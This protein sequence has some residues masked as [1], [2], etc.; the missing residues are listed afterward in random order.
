MNFKRSIFLKNI[1]ILSTGTILSQIINIG[2][3]PVLS[4]LYSVEDFGRL[5]LFLAFG[6]I[7]FSFSTL[8]LDLAIVKT[9]KEEEKM[10]LLRMAFLAVLPISTIA[11]V[12]LYFMSFWYSELAS[13]PIYLLFLFFIVNGG[14]Q[15]L[16]YYFN[17]RKRYLNISLARVL[18][19][20]TNLSFA[21]IL[22]YSHTYW[23][24]IYAITLANIFSFGLLLFY[25]RRKVFKSFTID[26]TFYQQVLLR[27][28]NFVKYSMPASFLDIL[29]YQIIIIILS[30]SFSEEVTG[31]FF[32]AMR[33]VLLPTTI[34][35]AAIGQVFYK[36]ISDKYLQNNLTK[37]EFLK[38]WK[39]LF[40]IG[41]L[42]LIFFLFYGQT[43]FVWALGEKWG[44]AGEMAVIL[45]IKGFVN[46]FSSPTS[47]G[48]LVI[49]K[50]HIN[51]IFTMIRMVYTLI[52]LCVAI[53]QNDIFFFLKWYTIAE[54]IQMMT[55]N[56]LMI[57]YFKASEK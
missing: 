38:I 26:F 12:G 51:L 16:I 5:A 52:F 32:M 54:V 29:S 24:L 27:N 8:K 47:S 30:I 57:T 56:F 46:F 43:L 40:V 11:S 31:A 7:V 19:A 25:L 33:V 48:F 17:S 9:E 1:F 22:S 4:R 53:L 23:G 42:P 55:Y 49:N 6:S 34:I 14:N 36:D 15:V 41:F 37:S 20:L 50:Q 2:G 45:S 44:L 21:F 28:I 3:L 10:V 13:L 18:V 39:T 35:G